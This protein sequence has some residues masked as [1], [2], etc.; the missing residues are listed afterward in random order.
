MPASIIDADSLLTVDIGTVSTRAAYF[1]VVEGYYRFIATGHAPTTAAA[2]YKDVGEGVRQAIENLQIVTGRK[3]LDDSKRL[4]MP[5]R[6]NT[7]VDKF[8]ATLSAGRTLNLVIA[9]LLN[10]VSIESAQKLARTLYSRVTDIIGLNDSRT[11]EQQIDDVISLQPDVILIAGGTDGGASSSIQH[12]IENIGLACYLL[13]ADKRPAVLYAG[14]TE[15]SQTVETS[16]QNLTTALS[17]SP[18]LRPEINTEDIQPAQNEL[19]KIFTHVRRNQINGIEQLNTWAGNTLLP[20]SH[21]EGRIIRFL[22][23][24]NEKGKGILGVDLGAS[25]ATIAAA[26]SGEL[27]LG[28][29]PQ[30]GVGEGL[31]NLLRYT[32]L[33]DILQWIPFEVSAEEVRDYIYQK[34]LYPATLPATPEDLAIEQAAARQCLS[35]ALN[36]AMKDFSPRARRAATN[37][38]PFFEP[39]LVNGSVITRA[40]S[41]V[42]SLL[43]I[44]DAI[45]PVGVT[46]LI[47]DQNNLL[48]ALGAAASRN[49][50]LPIQVL[51]SGAFLG[52]ATV[53]APHVAAG[54]GSVIMKGILKDQN[55][56]E[57]RFAVKQ[58]SMEILPLPPGASGKLHIRLSRHADIGF[59]AGRAPSAGIPVSGT[60]L[61]VVIDA[62]GRPIQ[63]PSDGERRREAIKKWLVT[64]GGQV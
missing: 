53:V 7:G 55:G 48:P 29:Y 9:G 57:S 11:M 30:L 15:L 63:L 42:Q 34:S 40:P 47:L 27:T 56:N 21:A 59:G 35:V 13:P 49:S 58:G 20:T 3:F 12:L 33:E 41:L 32:S 37:L 44:L 60:A 8:A 24:S 28:V 1:D 2:P 43:I 5:S 14:N 16:L 64:L 62:R 18:N 25:A 52:L 22:S 31:A 51:E 54:G 38:T 46:T 39:I 19:A 17:I 10:D 36:G 45:Q 23:S 26:F 6:E 50:A 61:G 4:I